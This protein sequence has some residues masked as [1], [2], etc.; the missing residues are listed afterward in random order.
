MLT[1]LKH[2]WQDFWFDE[3]FAKRLT[4]ALL[5]GYAL[6]AVGLGAMLVG[7][8]LLL[9]V[10]IFVSAGIAGAVVG[11]IK[12]GDKNPTDDQVAAA[13]DRSYS[14]TTE[15]MMSKPLPGAP[16]GAP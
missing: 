3:Q 8:P 7:Q 11:A 6:S 2:A 16:A 9:R 4:R 12:M 5:N 1:L 14:A 10:A 15:R 13:L